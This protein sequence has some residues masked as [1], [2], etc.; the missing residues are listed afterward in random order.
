MRFMFRDLHVSH[1]L[2]DGKET[3]R[4][5]TLN[6]NSVLSRLGAA[7]RCMSTRSR[8]CP[9]PLNVN[10]ARFSRWECIGMMLLLLLGQSTCCASAPNDR[11]NETVLLSTQGT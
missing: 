1:D 6:G 5:S 2:I 7:L 4:N 10:N 8:E 11:L 3:Y 9:L